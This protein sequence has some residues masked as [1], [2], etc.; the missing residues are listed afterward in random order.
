MYPEI[1]LLKLQPTFPRLKYAKFFLKNKP[2][3]TCPE[4]TSG[5]F[6]HKVI[7]FTSV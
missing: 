6:G 1:F 2:G 4:L 7:R 5:I 3:Y